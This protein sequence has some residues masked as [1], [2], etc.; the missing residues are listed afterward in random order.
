MLLVVV[1][2]EHDPGPHHPEQVRGLSYAGLSTDTRTGAL[3]L[4][5]RLGMRVLFTL[6]NYNL[7]LSD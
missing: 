5:Q 4:Y 6:N 3:D 7:A 1:D 2:L